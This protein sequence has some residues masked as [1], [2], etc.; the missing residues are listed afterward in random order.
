MPDL[1]SRYPLIQLHAVGAPRCPKCD[2]LLK[3]VE[4]RLK[5]TKGVRA[6]TKMIWGCLGWHSKVNCRTQYEDY[7]GTPDFSRELE[8]CV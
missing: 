8:Q 6:S 4:V 2:N 7:Y 1:H 5:N 3:R